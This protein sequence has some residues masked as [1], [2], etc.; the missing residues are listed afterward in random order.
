MQ[1]DL[2]RVVVGVNGRYRAIPSV[3]VYIAAVR[4]MKR[5]VSEVVHT[6]DFRL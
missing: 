2:R 1:G 5:R 4:N 6:S 3:R